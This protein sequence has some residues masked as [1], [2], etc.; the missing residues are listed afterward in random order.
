MKKPVGG[1]RA[2]VQIKAQRVSDK[3]TTQPW[4]RCPPN[5]DVLH[6]AKVPSVEPKDGKS[7]PYR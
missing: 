4:C 3:A 7:R 1:T 2:L 6:N 5:A